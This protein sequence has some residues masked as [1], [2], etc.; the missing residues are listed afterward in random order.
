MITII[1]RSFSKDYVRLYARVRTENIQTAKAIGIT[2]PVKKWIYIKE[3]INRARMAIQ[4]GRTTYVDDPLTNKLLHFLN[5]LTSLIKDGSN[6]NKNTIEQI[7]NNVFKIKQKGENFEK[8]K[9]F[10]DF[11]SSYIEDV[12]TGQRLRK[13]KMLK[14][15]SSTCDI[16]IVLKKHL[17]SFEKKEQICADWEDV[18][19]I[20][21]TGFRNYL[22]QKGLANNTI[23]TYLR[24]LK[25]ILLAAKKLRY[26]VCDVVTSADWI[27]HDEEVD[28]IYISTARIEQLRLAKLNDFFW[29]KNHTKN[30]L[31]LEFANKD[32]HRDLLCTARDLFVVGCLTGQRYSDFSRISEKMLIKIGKNDFFRLQQKKTEQEVYIP[33]NKNVISILRK[34]GGKLKKLN[35]FNLCKLMKINGEILGWSEEVQKTKTKGGLSYTFSVPFYSQIGTHTCRRSF[36]TNAYLANIPLSAIMAVTGHKTEGM[37]KKYLK[38]KGKELAIYAAKEFSKME[39]F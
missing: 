19:N 5:C 15:S 9:S 22:L 20:Y 23:T 36:A 29:I 11:I 18:N 33:A 28:N 35:R 39:I 10:H 32:T 24:R 7:I 25:T 17:E 12:K 3:D 27:P 6:L 2:L 34:N 13:R 14:I 4:E 16:F 30:K 31:I 37:L 26:P 1:A 8:Q 21:I 38:L